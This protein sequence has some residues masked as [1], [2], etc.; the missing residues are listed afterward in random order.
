MVKNSLSQTVLK[1]SFRGFVLLS[2]TDYDR[3]DTIIFYP[4][5]LPLAA[6][7]FF[8]LSSRDKRTLG[9]SLF[10][11]FLEWFNFVRKYNF[12]VLE[13]NAADRPDG[14]PL[15]T[16]CNHSSCLDD[17]C[18]WGKTCFSLIICQG[19]VFAGNYCQSLCT[20]IFFEEFPTWKK[21]LNCFLLSKIEEIFGDV[22]ILNWK[23]Y[24]VLFSKY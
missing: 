11:L 1:S 13:K 24:S 2:D 14:V 21:S 19:N 7:S 16:V 9:S 20:L 4:L 17:P 12:D 18:L 8:L 3:A 6:L 23:P 10:Y 22:N 15:V 5:S